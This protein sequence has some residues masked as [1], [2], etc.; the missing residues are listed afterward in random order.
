MLRDINRPEAERKF[1]PSEFGLVVFDEAHQLTGAQFADT[2]KAFAGDTI[3]L[4]FTATPHYSEQKTL[5]NHIPHRFFEMTTAEAMRRNDLCPVRPVLVKTN[6]RIDR[7]RLEAT[8]MNGDR[9]YNR[10]QLENLLNVAARNKAAIDTYLSYRDTD[11]G[12]QLFGQQGIV[13]CAG[14]THASDVARQF[15][16][17]IKDEKGDEPDVK[18]RKAAAR[19]WLKEN[20]ITLAAN[21]DGSMS[22]KDQDELYRKHEEGKILILCNA[23]LLKV[24]YDCAQDSFCMNLADTLSV[25]EAKQRNGRTFRLDP[26]DEAKFATNFDFIDEEVHATNRHNQQLLPISCSEILGNDFEFRY[27]MRRQGVVR[28]IKEGIPDVVLEHSE[29]EVITN[30]E[31]VREISEGRAKKRRGATDPELPKDKQHWVTGVDACNA[32]GI[33]GTAKHLELLKT[34]CERMMQDSEKAYPMAFDEND[35]PTK[36]LKVGAAMGRF[37]KQAHTGIYIDPAIAEHVGIEMGFYPSLP[38]N[39]SHWI[40]E[41]QV[42]EGIQVTPTTYVKRVS[43]VLE[44]FLHEKRKFELPDSDHGEIARTYRASQVVGKYR[45]NRGTYYFCDPRLCDAVSDEL[46]LLPASKKHWLS[47]YG[48]CVALGIHANEENQ[49]KLSQ[50]CESLIADNPTFTLP[51]GKDDSEPAGEYSAAKLIKKCADTRS[52]KSEPDYYFDP[53]IKG[54]VLKAAGIR[55][56]LPKEKSHW[57]SITSGLKYLGLSYLDKYAEALKVICT[58]QLEDKETSF[59]LPAGE[60]KK[61]EPSGNYTFQQ[62]IGLYRSKRSDATV[63]FDPRLADAGIITKEMVKEKA[64][65][66]SEGSSM[67]NADEHLKTKPVKPR[68]SPAHQSADERMEAK[69]GGQKRG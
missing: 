29:F 12:E 60:N 45:N 19:K 17:S 14:R 2:A 5:D 48:G 13:F 22:E 7:S 67:G 42:C 64:A 15:N 6:F 4:A 43:Q 68:I 50:A 23:D 41:R 63:Y 65:E 61:L 39:K 26:N 66:L 62:A 57:H 47:S 35:E 38:D 16:E 21:I 54:E 51:I 8:V 69:R 55:T 31:R 40:S 46:G 53:R 25:V 3:R 28:R 58:E 18:R 1:K 20:D 10:S 44:R 56:T 33:P 49:S 11:S 36:F 32:I 30:Y 52:K 27:P 24:G 34:T 59:R 37:R 9:H